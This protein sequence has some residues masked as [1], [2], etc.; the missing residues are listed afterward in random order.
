MSAGQSAV[1]NK[2][3]ALLAQLDEANEGLMVYDTILDKA[4]IHR[5]GLTHN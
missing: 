5:G 3:G 2:N 1:W 4:T